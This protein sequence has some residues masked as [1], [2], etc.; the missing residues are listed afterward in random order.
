MALNPGEILTGIIK[1]ENGALPAL[2]W[3][4]GEWVQ[5]TGALH[6][7]TKTVEQGAATQVYAAVQ[8]PA[9]QSGLFF[10]DCNE[11][12]TGYSALVQDEAKTKEFWDIS[13]ALVRRAIERRWRE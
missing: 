11:T 3:R 8:A 1:P 9:E 4:A 2:L 13:E 7:V 6:L 5:W 12:P 10:E